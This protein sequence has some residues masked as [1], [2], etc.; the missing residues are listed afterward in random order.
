MYT[1]QSKNSKNTFY[2]SLVLKQ[3]YKALG[4]TGANPAVGCVIVKK[5]S[6]IASGFTDIKGRPHAEQNAIN[7]AKHDLK[8]SELYVTLEPCSHQGKT[9]PCVNLI[10]KK[11]IKKVFFSVK[12]PDIRSFNKSKK[13][14]NKNKIM[15]VEGTNKSQIRRFYKSYYKLKSKNLPFI[16]A[17][18]AITK[19]FFSINKKCRWITNEFSR[20]RVHLIRS[21]H[22]CL[23]TSSITVANDN[24]ILNCR[25]SGL[26]DKSPTRIIL[27]KNLKISL[28]SRIVKS[29]K[30]INTIIFYNFFNKKKIEFLK[31]SKI[32]LFK[33]PITSKNEFDLIYVVKKIKT[34]GFSKILLEAGLTLTNVFLKKKLIDEFILFISSEKIYKNGANSFKKSFDTLLK[35]KRKINQQVNLFGDKLFLYRLK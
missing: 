3:A 18:I 2:M 26:E 24:P 16:T 11:K 7:S 19:D 13:K 12:D 6:V 5:N 35:S 21:T 30:K 14:F 15:V 8:N 29:A 1:N 34:L 20:A 25:I 31:K 22:D 32:K 9:P 28:S 33:I 27:D 10:V 17:K 23:L 4:N